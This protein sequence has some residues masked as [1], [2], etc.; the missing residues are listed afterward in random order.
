MNKNIVNIIGIGILLCLYSCF[1]NKAKKLYPEPPSNPY[2]LTSEAQTI[3]IKVKNINRIEPF[4]SLQ[5]DKITENN[6]IITKIEND[7]ITINFKTPNDRNAVINVSV[8][9]N[10]IGMN[11]SYNL[12]LYGYHQLIFTVTQKPKM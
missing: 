9:E 7:W 4:N 11:R 1:P 12:V 3:D 10:S 5:D 6:G 2:F 8:K